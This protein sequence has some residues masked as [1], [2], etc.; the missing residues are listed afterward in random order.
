MGDNYRIRILFDKYLRHT[1]TEDE[2]QE[3]MDYFGI[4][5]QSDGAFQ[6]L[7]KAM[8]RQD[9][10]DYISQQRVDRIA[11]AAHQRVMDRINR[12]RRLQRWPFLTRKLWFAA[13]AVVIVSLGV[14]PLLDI[15][16]KQ[17]AISTQ[18]AAAKI[19]PGSN[20]AMLTLADGRTIDLNKTQAGIIVGD[21]LTYLDG[22]DVVE[23][24]AWKME[25]EK[26]N[27]ITTPKGGSYQ[28]TLSDGTKVWLNAASTLKYPDKFSKD[29]RV[30]E[31]SGEAYF[32]IA[33]DPRRP[34][35]VISNGQEIEVLGTEFNLN[36]YKNEAA[37]QTTLIEG[38]VQIVNLK[39]G[40]V[41][42]L[43]PGEQSTVLAATTKIR[44]VDT[45]LYVAWKS[46]LFHFKQTPFADMM[47][48]IERWYDIEVVYK[49]SVPSKTFSGR[50][51][52]SVSLLTVLNLLDASQIGFEIE[53]NK[54]IIE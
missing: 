20:R 21:G 4:D 47:R 39:S 26:L 3:L 33:S 10:D 1:V 19:K 12:E 16:D 13:A 8:E 29:Q 31:F 51:R 28:I 9:G 42:R 34:F 6:L 35:K 5:G 43:V 46:E 17:D 38:S 14:W 7:L 53:G 36:A 41:D 52:R 48:Q 45:S 30:V 25:R 2:F 15:D 18:M 40:S 11:E 50:M 37:T 32:S 23:N 44:E 22:S 49:S 27:S 24:T 54:L